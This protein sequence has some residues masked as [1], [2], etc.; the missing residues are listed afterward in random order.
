MKYLNIT[1]VNLRKDLF[2]NILRPFLEKPTKQNVYL[3]KEYEDFSELLEKE[4]MV[5]EYFYI[6]EPLFD[7]CMKKF[8]FIGLKIKRRKI[9]EICF[10]IS[11][12][13][14]EQDVEEMY[15][16]R[17]LH[18]DF[19]L[20]VELKNIGIKTFIAFLSIENNW[21]IKLKLNHIDL[22]KFKKRRVR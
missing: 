4:D 16:R 10:I 22:E 3:C 11:M 17:Y 1:T 15:W 19:R 9:I 20:F 2:N 8:D 21:K 14:R 18:K 13:K 5:D 7:K 12:I 6:Y